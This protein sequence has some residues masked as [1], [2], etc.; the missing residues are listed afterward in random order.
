MSISEDSL[1]H[2]HYDTSAEALG[3]VREAWNGCAKGNDECVLYYV[4][5][6]P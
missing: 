5:G 3:G 6:F 1:L 4:A 2:I